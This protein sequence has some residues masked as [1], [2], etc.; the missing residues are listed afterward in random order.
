MTQEWG[1]LRLGKLVHNYWAALVLSVCAC[2]ANGPG[3]AAPHTAETPAMSASS[4]LDSDNPD[5]G[6]DAPAPA[7]SETPT[8]ATQVSPPATTSTS[9]R[10]QPT[11]AGDKAIPTAGAAAP[12]AAA[13]PP[14]AP[15]R[16]VT[17]PA[18]WE[19]ASHERGATP[20][21]PRLF[22][23]GKVQRIDIEMTAETRAMM[24]ADLTKLLG[25]PGAKADAGAQAHEPTDL[26]GGDPIYV[27]VSVRY[28]GHNWSHVAMRYK[29]NSS[30]ASG[31]Q[32]GIKKLGFRLD[33]DRLE[34]VYP[35]IADQRF[36]GFGKM[37]F[38]SGD[39]DP[40]LI[41]DKL[42]SDVL[43]DLGIP[44]ARCAFYQV[45]V[46]TDGASEYWGLY[47]MIEDPAD[48]M[49]EAQFEDKSGNLYKP[50]G[51]GADFTRFVKQSFTKKSNEKKADYS[52][53]IE[54][55]A[56]LNAPR[57][58]AQAWRTGLEAGFNVQSFLDVLAFSRTVGHWD[59]YGVIAHNYYLYGDPVEHGQLRWI[60]WD[61][62]LAWQ[63]F[64]GV[65]VMMDELKEGWPLIRFLLD[66]PVY[67]QQY[68]QA[69]SRTLAAPI[70]QPAAF[71]AHA[72][73]LHQLVQPYVIGGD[74][75]TGEKAPYTFVTDPHSFMTALSDP[76]TG[77]VTTASSL[78]KAVQ[79]AL[80]Q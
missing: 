3:L 13:A 53:V 48:Q 71:E 66:D 27:P 72:T 8:Q 50:E 51:P 75:L 40:S 20:D 23:D 4:E 12:P 63:R 79:D 42:A 22:A 76:M 69:L 61:H 78:R 30:L 59:S 73:G 77:L 70:L 18:G 56:A 31:W 44:T 16:G 19:K 15:E 28:D 39:R 36:Y 17:R 47:T 74:G 80:A 52:D 21:Y 62:N 68:K 60:S 43:T 54:A 67:R 14:E 9:P 25:E 45:Y 57:D 64:S 11:S 32:Q 49:I 1:V 10:K 38:A 41:R 26:V 24:L 6:A 46:S 29:G 55:I 35:E 37:T 65:S 34:D 58:D 7:R 5:A 33:F 2:G